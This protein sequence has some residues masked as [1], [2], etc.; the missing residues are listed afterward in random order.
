MKLIEENLDPFEDGDGYI[1]FEMEGYVYYIGQLD[2]P[3]GWFS[4]QTV[5]DFENN[6]DNWEK[7]SEWV[8]ENKKI[9]KFFSKS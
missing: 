7:V 2:G 4:R 6:R 8:P 5:D 1:Q 3:P 9:F